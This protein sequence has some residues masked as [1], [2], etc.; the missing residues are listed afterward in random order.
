[1]KTLKLLATV[2]IV[3]CITSTKV[4]A[5]E[6]NSINGSDRYETASLIAQQQDYTTAI[7]VN[8]LSLVDG[9]SASG[10]SGALNAPILLTQT[11]S[12][13]NTTLNS[14][15]KASTIYLVGGESVISTNIENSLINS[16]KRVIR[17][18]GAD[19]FTTSYSVASEIEKLKGVQEL[20]YVNGLRGEA[21]AMS[22][23]PV[24]AKTGNPV[25]LTNGSSTTYRREVPSYS[26]G[27]VSVLTNYFDD[28]C[29]RISG[30]DRFETNK[31]VIN[32]FFPNKNH[33]YL[34]K[35]EE[36]IDALT[37]SA[38]QEPVVL[39]SNNSEK[40][41]IAGAK[42]AT[43]LGNISQK[44]INH[45]KSYIFGEKVVFYVQH[46]DDETLFA[47]SA[48]V[49]AI[50]SVGNENVYIVLVTDGTGTYV[51]D[52]PR[53][54]HLSEFEKSQ[55]RTNEFEAA[56]LQLGLN[57]NNVICLNQPENNINPN[58]LKETA[59]YFENK[60]PSVT[61]ITH[62][63]VYDTHDQHLSSGK[64]LKELHTNNKIKDV[65]FFTR[66][67]EVSKIPT[68]LLIDSHAD[69]PIEKQ[70]VLNACQE[71]KLDNRD[72]IREGIGYKSVPDLFNALTSDNG[73]TS[74]LHELK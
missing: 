13:P 15:N 59:L 60:Y 57:L 74:Y 10:L 36:L 67:S 16:G 73:V 34:S 18:S 9:L 11:N 3:A 29:T 66:P 70:K 19:R 69:N 27:G 17:L 38:M 63:Y 42:S 39:I 25:I 68:N 20:Y 28:F 50:E 26:I 14:L 64:A 30:K 52:S 1:M 5:L 12:I 56:A 24:A 41:A 2:A 23:A 58:K 31:N 51:F 35:S 7:L 21:D 49:D 46:Q 72:M 61:H 48:I 37:S 33:V 47:G 4:S 65:R 43:A 55:L 62:S 32:K 53:Y 71:Y 54:S 40:T 22:I 6:L 45:A 8:G 44:A